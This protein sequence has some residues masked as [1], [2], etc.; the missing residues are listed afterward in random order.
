MSRK[1]GPSYVRAFSSGSGALARRSRTASIS[2][3]NQMGSF[4]FEDA[5]GDRGMCYSTTTTNLRSAVEQDLDS[6][7]DDLL[8][9]TFDDVEEMDM[10]SKADLSQSTEGVS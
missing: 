9:G 3:V 8:Q 10:D 2:H 6:A 4:L 5:R 1:V 7:L